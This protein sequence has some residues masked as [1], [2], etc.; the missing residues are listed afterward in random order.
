VLELRLVGE[1]SGSLVLL[2]GGGFA[3]WF[4]PERWTALAPLHR[5]AP[6]PALP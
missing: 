4:D 5:A 3:A 6:G 1:P 2:Q